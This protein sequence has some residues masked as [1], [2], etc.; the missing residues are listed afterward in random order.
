MPENKD[1][2][3]NDMNMKFPVIT[4]SL[5]YDD[6]NEPIHVDL[7]S[8]PPFIAS[9]IFEQV[10]DSMLDL[11]IGPKVTLNGITL[12][13]AEPIYGDLEFEFGNEDDID[14]TN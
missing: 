10:L 8:V 5:S 14:D 11:K 13:E 6:P 1:I 4:I 12:I 2:F 3:A 9:A 7:G